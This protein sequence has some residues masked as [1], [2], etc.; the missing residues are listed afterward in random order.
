MPSYHSIISAVPQ[1]LGKVGKA[2]IFPLALQTT[3][4][5]LKE[6]K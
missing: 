1:S 5:R 3:K 6:M 2:G 4:L